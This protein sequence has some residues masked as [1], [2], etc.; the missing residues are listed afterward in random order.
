M[1]NKISK[2]IINARQGHSLLQIGKNGITEAHLIELKERLKQHEFVKIKILKNSPYSTRSEAFRILE[3]QLSKDIK[4]VEMRGWT[5]IL[6][7][8]E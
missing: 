4:I 6:T 8:K 5:A 3:Q 7:L 1:K 2:K